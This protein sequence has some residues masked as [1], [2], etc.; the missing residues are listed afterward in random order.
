MRAL[1]Q[2]PLLSE[3]GTQVLDHLS[4]QHRIEAL[5]TF[6]HKGWVAVLRIKILLL[7]EGSGVS[8]KHVPEELKQSVI[9]KR[10]IRVGSGIRLRAVNERRGERV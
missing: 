10:E 3:K 8:I 1:H 2:V 4:V 9:L 6:R 5:R 7:S